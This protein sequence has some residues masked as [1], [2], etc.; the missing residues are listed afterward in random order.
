MLFF[1]KSSINAGPDDDRENV[2]ARV[3]YFIKGI[4]IFLACTILYA[5]CAARIARTH[6]T[7][8]DLLQA[9]EAA[10]EADIAFA[11]KEYY[12]ALIKYLESVR[13]NPNNEYVQNK[14]GVTY[15][16]LT[17]LTEAMD[18]FKRASALN[19]KYPFPYNNLG[20]MYFARQDLKMAERLFKKAISINTQVASF[21]LNLGRLYFESKKRDKA[22]L[23]LR[24][25]VALD[26]SVMERHSGTTISATSTRGPSS[27][28]NYSMA[29][30]YASVGD[31]I[32]AVESLQQALN[33]GFTNIQA[34]EKEPDFDPIRDNQ[35]FVAFMQTAALVL[36]P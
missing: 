15:A 31:A 21:H 25:A 28:T 5:G 17:Y 19:P 6:V 34:I 24:T 3:L 29:R 10:R 16:Q 11:R 7:D 36:R 26:P 22:M 13:L 32:R 1:A 18:S 8:E 20:S 9:N 14:L 23:E 30:V 35:L 12:S 2:F 33:A 27:E 4:C